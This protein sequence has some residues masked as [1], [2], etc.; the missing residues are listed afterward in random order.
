MVKGSE[1]A[2]Y[3]FIMHTLADD[4]RNES[5]SK[6]E[7]EMAR[8]RTPSKAEQWACYP[9]IQPISAEQMLQLQRNSAKAELYL[10]DRYEKEIISAL[11]HKFK[12]KD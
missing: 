5:Q 2:K 9:L 4:L 8:K 12:G 10:Q 6:D 7:K 3:Y 1:Y 11:G